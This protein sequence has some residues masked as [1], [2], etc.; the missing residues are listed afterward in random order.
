MFNELLGSLF[1]VHKNHIPSSH[2]HMKYKKSRKK[3]VFQSQKKKKSK[4]RIKKSRK[5]N[6]N[7]CSMNYLDHFLMSTRITFHFPTRT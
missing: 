4:K 1:N 7:E 2:T 5:E 6:E 3:K